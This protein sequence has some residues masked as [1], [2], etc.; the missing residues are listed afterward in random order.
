M[1]GTPLKICT[2]C[3]QEWHT[4]T[5]FLNDPEIEIIGYQSKF[6]ELEDGYFLFNHNCATTLAIPVDAFS[7]LRNGQVFTENKAGKKDCPG[8]CI[9][10]WEL[11][12]CRNSCECRWV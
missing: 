8:Y 4:V 3:N 5:D 11:G 6:E 7:H 1:S 12:T 9:Q 2:V 10:K